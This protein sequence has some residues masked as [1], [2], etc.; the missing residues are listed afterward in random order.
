MGDI[1]Q[2]LSVALN[3]DMAALKQVSQNLTN[4]HTS[5]YKSVSNVQGTNF[6]SNVLSTETEG[7]TKQLNFNWQ[8][9]TLKPTERSLDVAITGNAFFTIKMNNGLL[10]T[11]NGSFHLNNEGML[12]TKSGQPVLSESGEVYLN[13]PHNIKVSETGVI[14][15]N[16][17]EHA[18]LKLVSF[19]SADN[20]EAIGAGIW[21]TSELNTTTANKFS[22][23]QGYLETSNVDATAEMVK[24]ME[25]SKHFSSVQKALLAYDQMQDIG[26]NK[27]GQ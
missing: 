24:M 10:Y 17:E 5:G 27:F 16:G 7:K 9:G 25:L 26:I 8:N 12:M 1:I 4:T 2:V 3:R 15:Q 14:S 22:I 11:R 21:Q 23:N 19:I 18:Q 6:S 20:I 13:D